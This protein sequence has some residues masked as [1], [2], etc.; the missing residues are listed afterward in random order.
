MDEYYSFKCPV[1]G[2]TELIIA[3]KCTEYSVISQLSKC[4]FCNDTQFFVEDME[5]LHT[6]EDAL[7]RESF[8][9]RE[10]RKEWENLEEVAKEGGLIKFDE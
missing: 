9:C 8:S 10:C 7:E 5:W 3:Q 6:K 2:T 1:C 4:D